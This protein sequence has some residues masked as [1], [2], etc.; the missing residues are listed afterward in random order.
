MVFSKIICW[1]LGLG[2]IEG[3]M[4]AGS[5]YFSN[6]PGKPNQR[7]IFKARQVVALKM[8]MEMRVLV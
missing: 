7:A 4:N 3:A 5:S 1:Q 2:T 8:T 6:K